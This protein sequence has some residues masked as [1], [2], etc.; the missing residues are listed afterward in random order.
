MNQE[1]VEAMEKAKVEREATEKVKAELQTKLKE[2]T[3]RMATRLV[4]KVVI[5]HSC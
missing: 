1:L 3:D 4:F 5:R 2:E